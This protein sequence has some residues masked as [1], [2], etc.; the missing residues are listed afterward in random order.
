MKED[1]EFNDYLVTIPGTVA[2]GPS[3]RFEVQPYTNKA[4]EAKYRVQYGNLMA[5]FRFDTLGGYVGIEED[6]L[7]KKVYTIFNASTLSIALHKLTTGLFDVPFGVTKNV[8]VKLTFQ[9]GA[10]VE[11][12]TVFEIL[13]NSPTKF[14]FPHFTAPP[15]HRALDL[16][17]TTLDDEM[18]LPT[19]P[20]PSTYVP[21]TDVTN[22]KGDVAMTEEIPYTE[23]A[24]NVTVL[25]TAAYEELGVYDEVFD[26]LVHAA[27]SPA[28]KFGSLAELLALGVGEAKKALV[29]GDHPGTTASALCRLGLDVTGIDP[30]NFST[31]TMNPNMGPYFRVKG[32]VRFDTSVEEVEKIAEDSGWDLILVCASSEESAEVDTARNLELAKAFFRKERCLVAFQARS[33]P[34]GEGEYG[35][36][37]LPGHSVQG[38]E[39]YMWIRSLE[40]LEMR[41]PGYEEKIKRHVLNR[42]YVSAP[43]DGV[44]E[45]RVDVDAHG[46]NKLFFPVDPADDK[47]FVV[48]PEVWYDYMLGRHYINAAAMSANMHHGLLSATDPV[49]MW[50]EL[51]SLVGCTRPGGS[52]LSN[53]FNPYDVVPIPGVPQ[54]FFERNPRLLKVVN[55]RYNNLLRFCQPT[56]LKVDANVMDLMGSSGCGVLLSGLSRV[57]AEIGIELRIAKY[58]R[59]L[60]YEAMAILCSKAF[61]NIVMLYC[62]AM[63]WTMRRPVHA[64]ELQYMLW[65]LTSFGT[66]QEK[67]RYMADRFDTALTAYD[68]S[69]RGHGAV[70]AR[71]SEFGK[72]ERK[73]LALGLYSKYLAFDTDVQNTINANKAQA[74]PAVAQ[75][76][77][78][79]PGAFGTP[80]ASRRGGPASTTT[81]AG[82][83]SGSF[84]NLGFGLY[85]E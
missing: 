51:L 69:R 39:S 81:G 61:N 17:G 73:L 29:I 33:M 21:V 62:H 14:P 26:A 78:R 53:K 72:F 37:H 30:L 20:L 36:F 55:A 43:V 79:V 64:W 5:P 74:T 67:L 48:S 23:M 41:V 10:S 45:Y 75:V 28:E 18:D 68:T 57:R 24:T 46:I 12:E 38:A 15:T 7:N 54:A 60:P 34:L 52:A 47:K 25:D 85:Y 63:Q 58:D 6:T 59:V 40:G 32:S 76:T 42:L 56:E 82:R 49:E 27:A 35:I 4:F 13:P 16:V 11:F 3:T 65:S 77:P 44:S 66:W 9:T 70:T 80:R 8:A 19:T 31:V 2:S 50:A 1:Q 22:T 71:N 84:M 83:S